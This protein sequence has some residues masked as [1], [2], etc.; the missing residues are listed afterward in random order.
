MS[1]IAL[2]FIITLVAYFGNMA[3]LMGMLVYLKRLERILLAL[4][5][6]KT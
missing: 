3:I 6:E 4:M 1:Y 2:A 5:K